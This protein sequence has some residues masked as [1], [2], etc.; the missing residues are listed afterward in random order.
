MAHP[1]LSEIHVTDIQKAEVLSVEENPPCDVTQTTTAKT[2]G[3]GA[4]IRKQVIFHTGEDDSPATLLVTVPE[5]MTDAFNKL[6]DDVDKVKHRS[7]PPRFLHVQ[8][9]GRMCGIELTQRKF[10]PQV[11]A[12]FGWSGFKC[13]A[14]NN[15]ECMVVSY[16]PDKT[17]RAQHMWVQ[18]CQ[19]EATTAGPVRDAWRWRMS[20]LPSHWQSVY[21]IQGIAR[22]VH[23][24]L[25]RG[26]ETDVDEQFLI[27][28]HR[29]IDDIPQPLR[30]YVHQFFEHHVQ[31]L[32]DELEDRLK[33]IGSIHSI[34]IETEIRE[35]SSII[36]SLYEKAMLAEHVTKIESEYVE[37][38]TSM[39]IMDAE[40][41]NLNLEL[42]DQEK[43][44]RER[45][46]LMNSSLT[47]RKLLSTFAASKEPPIPH[48]SIDQM[49]QLLNAVYC[50]DY[51]PY[52]DERKECI[53]QV[54]RVYGYHGWTGRL[55]GKY[56]KSGRYRGY[57]DYVREYV[58]NDNEIPVHA[59]NRLTENGTRGQGGR[60]YKGRHVPKADSDKIYKPKWRMRRSRHIDE[61]TRRQVDKL[62]TTLNVVGN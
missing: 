54:L 49:N 15:S 18:Q 22:E 7:D 37:L 12:L 1:F 9:F 17:S 30:Y 43:L 16:F 58:E 19:E 27:S 31:S 3:I 61:S 45:A 28:C 53:K 50:L 62:E 34:S 56:K 51:A 13:Y 23:K 6:M 21:T 39:L 35:V 26:N 33:A 48:I 8:D 36:E 10:M 42:S 44:F 20:H 32:V 55:S 57:G 11:I 38:T 52:S 60:G 4:H 29:E 40:M 47:L 2:G 41:D 5:E 25:I 14:P 46:N 24:D 59:L